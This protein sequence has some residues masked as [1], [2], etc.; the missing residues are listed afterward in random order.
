HRGI[1]YLVWGQRL[2][3]SDSSRMDLYI[4]R[5]ASP[6]KL[7]GKP[8]MIASAD[9]AW[10]M[11]DP[12]KLKLEGPA[13]L[14]RNG[15]I[16]ISYSANAID[17][18]YCMG[19]LEM[20]QDADPLSASS[21]TKLPGPV[22]QSDPAA[23]QFGPGHNSFTSSRD[24]SVDYLVYHDRNYERIEGYPILDPNRNTRVQAFTWGPDGRPLFGKPVADGM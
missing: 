2:T 20:S 18:S 10:E 24:G 14:Q 1:R 23:R 12:S 8:V 7:L 13:V 5:M 19:M 6:S 9:Q 16:F 4:A 17:A 3:A 15:R 11:V 21:W 22:F